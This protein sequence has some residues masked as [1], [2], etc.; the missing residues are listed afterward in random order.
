MIKAG[1]GSREPEHRALLNG[2]DASA[3]PSPGSAVTC[4]PA[5]PFGLSNQGE[6]EQQER[7]EMVRCFGPKAWSQEAS[8]QQPSTSS[9]TVALP[10]PPAGE[11]I[12]QLQGNPGHIS[13][14]LIA[15][16]L[17]VLADGL[18]QLVS[19]GYMGVRFALSAFPHLCNQ[20]LALKF[21]KWLLFAVRAWVGMTLKASHETTVPSLHGTEPS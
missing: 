19:L 15:S 10:V 13:L 21:L 20:A 8:L 9:L 14:P 1:S 11:D 2:A 6:A 16:V 7:R 18:Q 12:T 4:L 3:G 5:E 17:A